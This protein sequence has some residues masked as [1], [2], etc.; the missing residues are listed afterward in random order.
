VSLK[1]GKTGRWKYEV[2]SLKTGRRKSE[3]GR[4]KQGEEI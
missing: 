4:M 2:G 3:V 1:D